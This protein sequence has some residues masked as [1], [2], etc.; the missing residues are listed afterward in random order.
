MARRNRSM[1]RK[2]GDSQ[3][4]LWWQAGDLNDMSYLQ[5]YNKLTELS[6]SMFEWV[7]LPDTMD[8]RFLELALFYDGHAVV[9][10]DEVMGMLGLRCMMTGTWEY[11][12]TVFKTSQPS[13]FGIITSRMIREMS[14]CLKNISTACSPS[15]ASITVKP[16]M[17]R[18]SFTSLRILA[19][20]STT[21]IFNDSICIVSS[22]LLI[23][24]VF[25]SSFPHFSRVFF[26]FPH[27]HRDFTH[28]EN[29]DSI[30]VFAELCP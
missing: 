16:L 11:W 19:S 20:S 15:S 27:F 3:S 28:T 13:I 17:V 24:F 23:L 2:H 9:F 4:G 6:V 29:R 12:R 30:S 7:N 1:G 21:N 10:K 26:A 5:Y 8:A 22:L 25:L 14:F 18:K